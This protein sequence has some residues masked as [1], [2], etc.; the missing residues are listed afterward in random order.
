MAA[1]GE[2]MF[3][4]PKNSLKPLPLFFFKSLFGRLCS[5]VKIN[6]ITNH[7]RLVRDLNF[8]TFLSPVGQ[9]DGNNSIL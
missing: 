1:Y 6:L 4:Q 9:R 7:I 8:I 3:Q 2:N 5:I